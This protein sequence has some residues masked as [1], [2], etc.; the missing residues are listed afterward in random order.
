VSCAAWSVCLAHEAKNA[1]SDGAPGWVQTEAYMVG[2][3]AY[4]LAAFV[5]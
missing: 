5:A 4:W 2:G 1:G 3:V